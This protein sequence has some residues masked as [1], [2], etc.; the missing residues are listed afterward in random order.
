MP[1]L[2]T[3]Q[4]ILLIALLGAACGD[5]DDA[6]TTPDANPDAGSDGDADGDTDTDADTD[7]GPDTSPFALVSGP[8]MIREVS[9]GHVA[10]PDITPLADGRILLVYR[11]A[12][13]HGVDPTGVITGQVG[14][15]DGLEWSDPV[16]LHDVPDV[17]DRDP[18]VRALAGGDILLSYFQYRYEETGDGDLPVHQIFLGR[19]TDGGETFTDFEL[20]PELA[21]EYPGAYIDTDLLW[22]DTLGDP[23]VVTACSNPVVEVGDRLVVQNYGG[24]AWNHD[25]PAAPKSQITLF[26]SDDDGGSWS[27][28]VVA[29][30]AAPGTWLQEPSLLALDADNWIM[31]VRTATGSSPGYLGRTWQIRSEDGGQT[32]GDWEQ[33]EFYGH[34][35]YLYR[36]ENG[37][38]LSAFRELNSG[39]T[40]AAV[41]FVYSD[42]DGASWSAPLRILD[43][44]ATEVGYP[45]IHQLDDG[46]I[47]F[48]YYFAGSSIRASIYSYTG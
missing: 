34:A 38:L 5:D 13:V 47:L 33:L 19:S 9:S 4:L 42:D 36:L 48:V 20:V 22:K 45:S 44:V 6:S 26:V 35:P 29:P 46:N 24:Y 28:Q 40:Q 30:D 17:D 8:I 7:T 25:N 39:G 37:L 15:A 14:T 32:W 41:S 10:F 2:R 31:H 16:T 18:S 11:E 1:R 27:E 12:A 23:V 21:M 43:W 3:P